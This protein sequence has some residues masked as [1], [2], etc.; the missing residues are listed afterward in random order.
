MNRRSIIITLASAGALVSLA[1]AGFAITSGSGPPAVASTIPGCVKV[2][3]P[4]INQ[5]EIAN[6]ADKTYNVPSYST[7][8]QCAGLSAG[9]R[10]NVADILT[11]YG[12]ADALSLATTGKPVAPNK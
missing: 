10:L 7:I 3:E 1:G 6:H 8:P 9:Q 2:M 12:I 4:F 11:R 5:K